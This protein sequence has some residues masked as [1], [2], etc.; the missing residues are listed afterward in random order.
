M[1]RSLF[2]II[3]FLPIGSFCQNA[4]SP[5]ASLNSSMVEYAPSISADNKTLMLQS[6][7]EGSYK[8]YESKQQGS[9]WGSPVELTGINEGGTAQ[10]LIGGPSISYDGNFIYFFASFK[11]GYGAEDIYYSERQGSSWSHPINIGKPL[12]SKN[13]EGFPS[14]SSD[15]KSI[16]FMRLNNKSIGGI[17]C[18]TLMVSHREANGLWNTPV[19][20]P[21]PVNGGCDKYPRIMADNE[22]L[23]FT[24][25][26]EGS[27]NNS[28]DLFESRKIGE[29]QWSEPAAL[30]FVNTEQ[31][32]LFATV[33]SQ[34]DKLYFIS[35]QS[36]N[37]D[38]YQ[39][40][41]PQKYRPKIVVNIQGIIT[42]TSNQPLK[43]TMQVIRKSDSTE[44][45]LLESNATSGSFT[46]VLGEGD[47]DVIVRSEG[48]ETKRSPLSTGTISDYRLIEQNFQLEEF[49]AMVFVD[50]LNA[51]N[52][53]PLEATT[54]VLSE[55]QE[56]SFSNGYFTANY[57]QK[58]K[59]QI[60]K[61]GY[62]TVEFDYDQNHS[63]TVEIH[64]TV[65][66]NPQ[67]PR[68]LIQPRDADTGEPIP[69][70]LM[71]QDLGRKQTLF[72]S[73]A[74]GDTTLTLN[75]D[76]EFSV[77]GIA[78][79]YL[80][81]KDIVDLKGVEEYQLIEYPLEMIP[82]K[83]G[84]KLTLKEILFE[85]GS[86][87][88]QSSS[89]SELRAVFDFLKQN[90]TLVVEISAHSDNVGSDTNNLRLSESRAQSVVDY[91]LKLGVPQTMLVGKG[92]GETQPVGD[93]NTEEGRTLNRRVDFKVLK[94]SG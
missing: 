94:T 21:S 91:L 75:F 86:A 19:A 76:G 3:L 46:L 48:Y 4:P 26:R 84:A 13:Y 72:K 79:N 65:S 14:I 61:E 36:G 51:R 42:N 88:I 67:K 11:Q 23:I 77:Y 82:I 41:I 68:I 17:N 53:E 87:E 8:L 63:D 80:F 16:Y 44:V 57:Q 38:L 39:V 29:N 52:Q 28:W 25:I 12:N 83:E 22:T 58:F 18:Y 47:Y 33:S 70:R 27:I 37:Y 69:I 7:R 5:I 89:E 2:L 32:E 34:G 24:S 56:I 74:K 50:V 10:D 30:E 31:E 9:T 78:A 20:L 62:E 66:L 54:S 92:Y 85:F 71:V 35:K 55:D 49:K 73:V 60:E 40:D 1:T 90:R 15:G 93:N 81:N 43:S 45:A 64:R 6:D 59:I